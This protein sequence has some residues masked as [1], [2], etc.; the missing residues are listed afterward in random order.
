MVYARENEEV[1][2]KEE[3]GVRRVLSI[4]PDDQSAELIAL[5][6][7]FVSGGTPDSRFAK[8]IDRIPPLLQNIAEKGRG[9]SDN[10]ISKE[11]VSS[12]NQRIEKGSKQL[13]DV[14][15]NKLEQAVQSGILK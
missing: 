1:K 14:M 12:V 10:G 6:Q 8:A 5:W 7:E 15:R 9:W 3:Q 2:R 11:Q 13:W 4:L